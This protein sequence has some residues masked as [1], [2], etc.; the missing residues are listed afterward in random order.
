MINAEVARLRRQERG[1][2]GQAEEAERLWMWV[3]WAQE[4]GKNVAGNGNRAED[5]DKW[6]K[7]AQVP[8]NH[9]PTDRKPF[10]E[11]ESG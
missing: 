3:C 10:Y 6:A 7:D 8:A 5:K 11:H 9:L 4:G 1:Y 2:G